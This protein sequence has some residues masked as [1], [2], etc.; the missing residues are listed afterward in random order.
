MKHAATTIETGQH[1]RIGPP[2]HIGTRRWPSGCGTS[3]RRH[4]RCHGDLAGCPRAGS[5]DVG[6]GWG[7]PALT[8]RGRDGEGRSTS[9]RSRRILHERDEREDDRDEVHQVRYRG[10]IRTGM[11]DGEGCA[12]SRTMQHHRN[13]ERPGEAT[14]HVVD[15]ADEEGEEREEELADRSPDAV[16]V[17][18]VRQMERSECQ[19]RQACSAPRDRV[20]APTHSAW[21]DTRLLRPAQG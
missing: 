12:V 1:I 3:S 8:D 14:Q 6:A 9:G 16:T 21:S 7:R 19:T 15:D 13:D 17:E 2:R 5:L 20:P 4:P 18:R 10:S 11:I